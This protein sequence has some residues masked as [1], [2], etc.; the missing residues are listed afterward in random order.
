MQLTALVSVSSMESS[1]PA[2]RPDAEVGTASTSAE[3][4][5]YPHRPKY[6]RSC[7]TLTAVP[8]RVLEVVVEKQLSKRDDSLLRY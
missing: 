3:R 1:L 5:A 7:H 8:F 6:L 2:S 4:S